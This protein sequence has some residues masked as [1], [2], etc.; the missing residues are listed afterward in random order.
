MLRKFT[1]IV[2]LT[3]GSVQARAEG[4]D[5]N[6]AVLGC[7]MSGGA[8]LGHTGIPLIDELFGNGHYKL[9]QY[10]HENEC[11]DFVCKWKT[12]GNSGNPPPGYNQCR[13][14]K[15]A[16]YKRQRIKKGDW[17]KDFGQKRGSYL[18]ATEDDYFAML[19]REWLPRHGDN[20]APYFDCSVSQ[21]LIFIKARCGESYSEVA[22][23]GIW[24]EG[25]YVGPDGRGKQHMHSAICSIPGPIN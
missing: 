21:R 25:A 18:N 12:G 1:F 3:F 4:I 9:L 2:T 23:W 8:C 15:Q 17:P 19:E 11:K 7:I 24:G 16:Y 20:K 10:T 5:I 14:I 22:H 6:D 13:T